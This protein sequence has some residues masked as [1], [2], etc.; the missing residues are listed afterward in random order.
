MVLAERSGRWFNCSCQMA[1]SLHIPS[2]CYRH[3]YIIGAVFDEIAPTT[4]PIIYHSWGET[5][6]IILLF[7]TVFTDA[8]GS[9]PLV[10][11]TSYE[12][13]ATLLSLPA[14]I[15]LP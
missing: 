2:P 14:T 1:I 10:V 5:V 13:D 8:S 9:I 4:L 11:L 15:F 3:S 12:D 7:G 6:P